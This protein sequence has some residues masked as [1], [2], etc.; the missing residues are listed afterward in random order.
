MDT[1]CPHS[2][3]IQINPEHSITDLEYAN[4]LALFADSYDEMA[5]NFK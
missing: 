5:N 3:G 2:R 4:D 1:A